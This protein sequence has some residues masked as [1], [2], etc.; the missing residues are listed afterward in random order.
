LVIVPVLYPTIPPRYNVL[1][2]VPAPP[3]VPFEVAEPSEPLAPVEPA[4][5]DVLVAAIETPVRVTSC[6][7][8]VE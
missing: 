5:P 8:F 7:M 3:A 2:A 4:V 6:I 1:P